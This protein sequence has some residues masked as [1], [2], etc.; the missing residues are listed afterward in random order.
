[1]G[2]AEAMSLRG[3]QDGQYNMTFDGIPLG[4]ATDLHHT[5]SSLFI[6]HFLGEAQIDRGPGTGSTIGNATFGGTMGFT[7]KTP[8]PRG[9]CR[10]MGPM[11][12][13]IRV[14]AVSNLIVAGR[15]LV[16]H[17]SICSMRKRTDI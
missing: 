5:T 17:F 8:R 9:G 11:A 1:M 7:S 13:L 4:D 2:K 12:A 16:V 10:C 6:L 14:Q 3:F 15:A